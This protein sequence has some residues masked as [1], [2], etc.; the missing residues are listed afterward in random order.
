MAA[1]DDAGVDVA[2]VEAFFVD[3]ARSAH[4]DERV[5]VDSLGAMDAA[6]ALL[7]R[8]GASVVIVATAIHAG[9]PSATK[10]RAATA[11]VM[12]STH[13]P[14]PRN[15]R[16]PSRCEAVLSDAAELPPSSS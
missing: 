1:L 12:T 6:V 7:E 9:D 16:G 4:G 10:P 15:R 11:L 3:H 8:G 5:A 2:D 14:A 13:A